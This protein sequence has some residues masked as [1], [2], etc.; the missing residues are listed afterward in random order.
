MRRIL[1]AIVGL[2]FAGLASAEPALLKAESNVE[3]GTLEDSRLV[4][5]LDFVDLSFVVDRS[6]TANAEAMFQALSAASKDGRSVQVWFDPAVASVDR[7][8]GLPVFAVAKLVAGDKTILGYELSAAPAGVET[9][10]RALAQGVAYSVAG[11]SKMALPLLDRALAEKGLTAKLRV[12]ALKTRADLREDDALADNPPGEARDQAL[13]AALDDARAWQKAAPDEAKA[14]FQVARVLETLGAYDD[15]IAIYKDGLLRWPAESATVYRGLEWAYRDLGKL[16]E[17][18]E[19]LDRLGAINGWNATMPYHY[20]RGWLFDLMDL[21]E[22][23]IGEYTEGLKAQPDYEG[24][25][26]RRSCSYAANG[27]IKEAS[28]DFR[29]FLTLHARDMQGVAPSPSSRF[30]DHRYGEVEQILKQTLAVDP[31]RK[32]TGLCEG[33]WDWGIGK[34]PRSKLLP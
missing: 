9:A 20:H 21:P 2:L 10:E 19:W 17:A 32:V 23:A 4:F 7:D 33:T 14:A 30:D 34:R 28:D 22:A 5:T 1:I 25:F 18:S 26:W 13:L 3:D 11:Q 15:A 27:Q 6:K 29:T 31:A 8:K 24:A 12:L 16:R